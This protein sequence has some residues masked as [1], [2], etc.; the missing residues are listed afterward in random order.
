MLR[1]EWERGIVSDGRQSEWTARDLHQVEGDGVEDLVAVGAESVGTPHV[2][3]VA[4][5]SRTLY[6]MSV[7]IDAKA[8]ALG[9][10]KA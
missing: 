6:G 9:R 3:S 10:W 4:T 5:G 1:V 2:L 7:A 8:S